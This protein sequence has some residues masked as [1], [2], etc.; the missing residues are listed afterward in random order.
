MQFIFFKL[1]YVLVFHTSPVN[2]KNPLAN[3][4]KKNEQQASYHGIG[5]ECWATVVVETPDANPG[6]PKD[7]PNPYSPA[8]RF[9]TKQ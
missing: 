1:K 5:N 8:L 3:R 2:S 9:L 6:Q 4:K 7:A